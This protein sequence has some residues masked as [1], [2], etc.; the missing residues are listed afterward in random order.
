MAQ[1]FFKTSGLYTRSS[2]HSKVTHSIDDLDLIFKVAFGFHTGQC[3][4]TGGCYNKLVVA[5]LSTGGGVK[6]K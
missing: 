3:K 1:I 4:R 2:G 5:F 6:V